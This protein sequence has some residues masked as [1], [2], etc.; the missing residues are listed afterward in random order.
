MN[1][2]GFNNTKKSTM[3]RLSLYISLLLSCSYCSH[4]TS[5]ALSHSR[6]QPSALLLASSQ[7]ANGNESIEYLGKGADAIV[8]PGVVLVPPSFE[9]STYL[10]ECALFIHAM[11]FD[12]QLEADVIR[13]VVIDYP[14]AFTMGEMGGI[15]GKL[16]DNIIYR[17]GSQGG[18]SVMMLHSFGGA[19]EIGT[20]G[21]YEG[22][23]AEAMK[24]CDNG[25]ANPSQFKFFFNYCQ[26]GTQEL[27]DIIN[28]EEDD[29][30]WVSVQVPPEMVLS[31]C[32]DRG[33]CWKQLR[34]AIRQYV[35][36]DE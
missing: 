31:D 5:F 27:E 28:V 29:D 26:F 24:A 32:N 1:K 19:N 8:R 7:G 9:F 20:S 25:T 36:S 6:R 18:D 10:R 12:E 23:L 3:R 33:E 35:R 22:G 21:I 17:G 30:G 34:N 15:E 13:G 2:N 16:A 14:T 4:A 11:G